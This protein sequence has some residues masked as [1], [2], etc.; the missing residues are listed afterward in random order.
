[1]YSVEHS[2]GSVT[3][4]GGV[5]NSMSAQRLGLDECSRTG[6]I[7]AL[8]GTYSK[9][10]P[11]NMY[12]VQQT[13]WFCWSKIQL[14]SEIRRLSSQ[15]WYEC[16]RKFLLSQISAQLKQ[17]R[18]DFLFFFFSTET[19]KR[20][21]KYIARSWQWSISILRF[22]K[23]DHFLMLK[24]WLENWT[25]THAALY[26]DIW[27]YMLYDSVVTIPTFEV[28]KLLHRSRNTI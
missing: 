1:M 10:Q 25:M 21:P 2:R 9:K 6:D 12:K 26:S 17:K 27:K 24:R 5:W 11:R 13:L 22:T 15:T 4:L 14:S 20:R 7:V 18:L 28:C 23:M 19:D 3:W 8:K 16:T